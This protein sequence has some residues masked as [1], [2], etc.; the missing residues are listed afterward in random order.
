[1]EFLDLDRST[2]F[3]LSG[4]GKTL[5]VTHSWAKPGYEPVRQVIAQQE[6][7][8]GLKKVLAGET[9]VFAS[10]EELPEE[11]ARDRETLRKLGP[12]SNITFPLSAGGAEVLG[13]LAFGKMSQ[14]RTWPENLVRRLGLFAQ[15]IANALVRKEADQTL[16]Q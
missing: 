8:W 9:I 11:A 4:D 3:Q 12:K 5:L 14:E 13:A 15:I 6:L 1:V 10:V 16:R 2:L 7:P